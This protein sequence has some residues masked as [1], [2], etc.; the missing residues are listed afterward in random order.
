MLS[1]QKT[2]K[3][4]H[5]F[6]GLVHG[7]GPDQHM[8]LREQRV[9]SKTLCQRKPL[10]QASAAMLVKHSTSLPHDHDHESCCGRKAQ[11]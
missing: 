9:E 4:T 7:R 11:H 2:Q 5:L 3:K 10:H 6:L 8:P 1:S